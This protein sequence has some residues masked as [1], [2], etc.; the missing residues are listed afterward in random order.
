MTMKN[1][2][3]QQKLNIRVSKY[4]CVNINPVVDIHSLLVNLTYHDLLE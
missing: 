3:C 2:F 4:K 1:I